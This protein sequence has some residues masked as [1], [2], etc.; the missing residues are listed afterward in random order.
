MKVKK[1]LA[2]SLA[3]SMIS[4][5][6]APL[7]AI[8]LPTKKVIKSQV[9]EY[10]FDYVNMDWWKS[11]N[12][13][14]LEDYIIRAIE[15]NQD[16]KIATLRV[17]EYNQLTKLQ[18]AK[19][20]PTA[21]AGFSPNITKMPGITSSDSMYSFPMLV[22]YEADIFL[23]NHDKTKSQKKLY[24]ASKIDEKAAYIAI[25]AAVGS[26]YL[27]IVKLDE[28]VD[29]QKEMVKSRKKI[30]E[31]MQK[32]Y[33]QGISSTTD[34]IRANKSY[35]TSTND[36]IELEK[37]RTLLLN[38]LAIL[39]GDSPAN[40]AELKRIPYSELSYNINIPQEISSEVITQRPD[41]L[42]AEKMV[43]KAGLDVKIA[44][45]E[46]LPSINILGLIFF[47]SSSFSK[48]LNW[49]NALAAFGGSALLPLFTGGQRIAN[50][51]I[52]KNKY[53]QVLQNY[54][55]TNLIAIQEV[56]D[57]LNIL[58]LDNDKYI[59]NV[60]QYKMEEKTYELNKRKFD[61]GVISYLDLLQFKES[62]LNM[63][64][65]LASSRIDCAIDYIG[66]Y[67]S[68]GNKIN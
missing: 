4:T 15:Q 53:E 26:T 30:H 36:L 34:V 2:I 55:K 46:F 39:T 5:N 37:A 7:A 10:R 11:F 49:S 23:K 42:K 60:D 66:L 31:L 21:T 8:S 27:N 48:S 28:L 54:L 65:L 17:E 52:S 35:V 51:K 33:D 41:Y 47:N 61:Q 43:E 24:E 3:I 25:A 1:I 50:L 20:F 38:K 13:D 19:E 59:N 40:V 57:S 18:R 6:I 22:N 16:L 56:N 58:K 12:D 67:K 32:R 44:K 9:T 68:S 64:K 29:I 45:K 14:I 63:N 62:L